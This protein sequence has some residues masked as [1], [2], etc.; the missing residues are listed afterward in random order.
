MEK[1]G[2]KE[3]LELLAGVELVAVTGIEVAKDGL[4]MDD[5]AKA[6]ELVKKSEV[7]VEAVKGLNLVDDEVKDLDQAELLQLGAASFAM[8]KKIAAASKKQVEA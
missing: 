6:V 2:I 8:V 7:L 3:S 4:G 1:L 5:L